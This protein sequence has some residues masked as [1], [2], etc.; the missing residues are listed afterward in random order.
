MSFKFSHYTHSAMLCR[1]LEMHQSRLGQ[2]LRRAHGKWDLVPSRKQA[3]YKLP[4]T[5]GSF[6]DP[7]RVP[8]PLSKQDCCHSNRQHH[9]YC[10]HKQGRKYEVASTVC[11]MENLDLVLQETVTLGARHIPGQLN[12]V[13]NKLCRLGQSIQTEWSLL[14]QVFKMICSRCHLPQVDLLATRFKLHHFV[15]PVADTLAW[16]VDVL[17]LTWEDLDP[18]SFPL[19]AI[20]GKMVLKPRDCPCRRIILITAGWPNM[21]WFWDLV[22]LLSHIHCACPACP[23]FLLNHLITVG[24]YRSAITAP[25]NVSKDNFHR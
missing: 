1:S 17:S 23:I 13:A 16:A 2:L 5:K 24:G 6:L 7:K 12:I 4:G 14:P 3:T 25:I 8:R 15:S 21:P 20:L 18:F 22:S 10:L 11:P 19:V 9:S